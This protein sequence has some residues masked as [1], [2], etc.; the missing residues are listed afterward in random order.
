MAR[1]RFRARWHENTLPS[2]NK[3]IVPLISCKRACCGGGG[4]CR[5][6]ALPFRRCGSTWGGGGELRWAELGFASF[7]LALPPPLPLPGF[8]PCSPVALLSPSASMYD[9][10]G[11]T[12]SIYDSTADVH[13]ERADI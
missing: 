6:T 4:R 7:P 8:V 13:G 2:C 1:Q 9:I 12:A 10:H 3:C 11:G 5:G